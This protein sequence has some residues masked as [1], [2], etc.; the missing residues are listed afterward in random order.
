[1]GFFTADISILRNMLESNSKNKILRCCIFLALV[2]C[3]IEL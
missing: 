2:S 3:M 1:M